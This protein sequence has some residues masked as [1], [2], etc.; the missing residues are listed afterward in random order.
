MR[1]SRQVVWLMPLSLLVVSATPALQPED[2]VRQGNAAFGRGEFD[3]ALKL[4]ERAEE[5]SVD[6]GL[7]A[8]NEGTSLYRE[9]RYR[10]AE[11]HYRRALEGARGERRVRALYDLG[12]CLLQQAG[13]SDASGLEEAIRC[14]EHCLADANAAAELKGNAGHNLELSR[15]LLLKAAIAGK[16]T[17]SPKDTEQ[18]NEVSQDNQGQRPMGSDRASPQ[19]SRPDPTGRTGT[20]P[21][22]GQQAI[23]TTLQT[24]G[25]GNL[26]PV[27]DTEE[28]VPL[29]PEDTTALLE[30][31]AA[32]I[33]REQRDYRQSA[34]PALPKV[35]D[36]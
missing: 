12:N 33:L 13:D 5:R 20:Q 35:K 7:L 30:R 23:E 10:A 9:G 25:K 27:P 1:Y 36:W 19:G 28:L 3:Q 15:L 18:G 32:R 14:Y 34:A 29:A 6:P 8:F 24:P 16:D 17:T 31:V 22:A 26:R 11:M 4:Y 2:L 21:N